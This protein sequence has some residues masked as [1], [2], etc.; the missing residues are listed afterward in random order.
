[1]SLTCTAHHTSFPV[2][3]LQRSQQFY[4]GVLGL[5][6]IP[7]PDIFGLGGAWYDAGP[8]E[9]HLI[10]VAADADVGAQPPTIDPR[11][12]HAAFAVGDY[13]ETVGYLRAAGLDIFETSVEFG[14]CW[15]QDPDGHVIEFIARAPARSDAAGG[16][17]R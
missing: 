1:M 2:R 3:D 5:I 7:R 6:E 12:R 15:V 16:E 4:G 10:E 14:Q 9:L 13:A 17:S 8:I 11:A